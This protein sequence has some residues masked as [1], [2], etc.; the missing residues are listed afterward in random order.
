M[1]YRM[2]RRLKTP[3]NTALYTN[4]L[5]KTKLCLAERISGQ[6]HSGISSIKNKGSLMLVLEE[7]TD[8]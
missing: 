1:P 7:G 3:Q 4:A 8:G 6:I 5:Q 2:M